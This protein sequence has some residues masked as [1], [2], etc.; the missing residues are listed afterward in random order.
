MAGAAHARRTRTGARRRDPRRRHGGALGRIRLQAFGHFEPEMSLGV[1]PKLAMHASGNID[2][3]ELR[4]KTVVVVG[5]GASAVD[6]APE[7]LEAGAARVAM[8]VRRA[9]VPR[10]NKGMGIGSPGLWLGFSRLTLAQRWS[11]VQYIE[12]EAIPPPRDSMLRCSRHENFSVIT[13]CTPRAAW[14][15]D[16]RV[17]LDTTR[18]LRAFDYLILATGF[19]VDWQRRREL[20][21]LAPHVLVWRDR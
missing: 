21:A 12:D 18:G 20:A 15:E 5:A 8:P 9:E 17:F 7:A 19:T 16:R 13:R 3:A 1:G 11:I 6:Q 4:G 10:V 14:I 2:C